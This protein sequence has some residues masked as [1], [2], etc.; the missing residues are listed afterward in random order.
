LTW[1]LCLFVCS[2]GFTCLWNNIS[3]RFFRFPPGETQS[4]DPHYRLRSASSEQRASA[5]GTPKVRQTSSPALLYYGIYLTG[6]FK[7]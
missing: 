7:S 1:Y 4:V 6:L 2:L 5:P 3:S